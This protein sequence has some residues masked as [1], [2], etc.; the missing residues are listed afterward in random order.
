MT[1]D[2]VCKGLGLNP[3]FDYFEYTHLLFYSLAVMLLMVAVLLTDVCTV[4]IVMRSP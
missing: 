1:S 4:A 3:C 2:C